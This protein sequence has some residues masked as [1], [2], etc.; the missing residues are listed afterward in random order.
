MT[1]FGRCCPR[2][3]PEVWP[4]SAPIDKARKYRIGKL[5]AKGGMGAILSAKDLNIR[6]NV[7][8]KVMLDPK[9]EDQAKPLRFIEEGQVA[10]QLE[11]P[12]IV[13][14]YELGIDT[15]G[16]V[17]YTMKFVIGINSGEVMAGCLGSER[18][19]DYTV[20][21]ANPDVLPPV[22]APGLSSRRMGRRGRRA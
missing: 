12:G 15:S 16:N 19:M 3:C 5:V 20:L 13:P 6:R 4:I 21:L 2:C 18:R 1:R 14:I 8:M 9:K 22:S 7:A 17:F 10:G 11:H